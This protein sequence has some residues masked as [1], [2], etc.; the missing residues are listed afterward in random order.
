[1]VFSSLEFI[2][3][4]L[5]AFMLVYAFVP[6]NYKNA[7]I[8]GGSI[9]FYAMG[10]T[11]LGIE[12]L[13]LYTGLF[14]L[15]VLLNFIIGE[16]I[17]NFR[18]ASKIWL[19]IG[20]VFNFWWLLFFKYTGFAL[21]N[22]NILAGGKLTIKNIILP[23]GIS[24]Y[25]FQNVSYIVDVYRKKAA[26]EKNF[27]NYGAYISMFPQLIAGPIVTYSTVAEQLK[28]RTHS[29]K[30][31][32]NGLKTFTI[33]L[34][35]K[36]LIANQIG[37]LWSDLSMIGYQ[38]ISTPLAWLGIIA[39][40]FQLYFDFMGYSFMAMGLGEIMGFTIPQNFNYPYLSTSMTEFWRRWHITLGSWFR[41]YIYIPLGGS[42]CSTAKIVRNYLIV[43]L[44][45][46]LWHGASWNFVLWGLALFGLIML[47]RFVIG[48]FLK[49]VPV[50]GHLYMFLIIPLTW[51]LFAITDFSQLGI[52]FGKLFGI[53]AEG[54][55][56]INS[57]DYVKYWGIYG[58]YF[59][60]GVIFS[61][62]IPELIYKKIKGSLFCALL[63]LA[64]FWCSV[65][66]MYKGMDDPFLYFRF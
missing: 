32:E 60:A 65:Y 54:D 28:N 59:I 35:Y 64:V 61:T 46:G 13:I 10:F 8:F 51:L 20:I 47:E 43:W 50:V 37:G 19:I 41:E 25:T 58:K 55:F 2:F 48:D 53:A 14:L 40:S 6:K 62:K 42:R 52:Y 30:K 17:S 34:G 12:K 11:D 26:A 15:T 45:T 16:F 23:I 22:L 29:I 24:F 27:I 7:I 44:F 36:V 63:L 66:C 49:A 1:M 31:V 5:P 9:L 38:S 39:F 33:G 18:R 56:I 4:F 3:L 21:E 57:K